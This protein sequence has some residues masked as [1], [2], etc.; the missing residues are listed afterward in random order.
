MICGYRMMEFL[1]PIIIDF[2][3]GVTASGD[4][5][6]GDYE[7]ALLITRDWLKNNQNTIAFRTDI[8]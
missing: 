5:N 1:A 4:L 8:Y 2:P 3:Y 7:S 6:T